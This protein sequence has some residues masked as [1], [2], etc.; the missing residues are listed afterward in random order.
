[1]RVVNNSALRKKLA[2]GAA[3][4]SSHSIALIVRQ[5]SAWRTSPAMTR[6]SVVQ[7]VRAEQPAAMVASLGHG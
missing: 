3:W 7:G 6:I 5:A 4:T 1:M 2:R